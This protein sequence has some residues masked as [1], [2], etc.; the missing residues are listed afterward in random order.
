MLSISK[1][2]LQ[3]PI[4]LLI[5]PHD[6]L[7]FR[8]GRPYGPT[9][10]AHSQFPLPQTLAGM[11][12][13][14]LM[15]SLELSSR[16]IHG[17]REN[18]NQ[19]S[20][21]QRALAFIACRGPWLVKVKGDN[22]IEDLFVPAPAHLCRLDKDKEEKERSALLQPLENGANLPGWQSP[23][24]ERQKHLRPV[25]Y[26]KGPERVEPETRWLGKEAITSVLQA[27]VP[28]PDSLV[29]PEQLFAWENRTGVTI[30]PD[31]S[32]G[33]DSLLYSSSQLRFAKNVALYAEIGWETV[34]E[35]HSDTSEEIRAAFERE[36]GWN[37][38]FPETGVLL[39][40]GGEARRTSVRKIGTF[41]WPVV[42]QAPKT[43]ATERAF[44]WLISP[45]V[46]H[47]HTRTGGQR[48]PWEP[49]SLGKLVGAVCPRYLPV[50]GWDLAG[51]E[52]NN[53]RSRPRSTRYAVP[54]GAVYFWERRGN[55]EQNTDWLAGSLVQLAERPKDRANGWGMALKGVW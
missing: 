55:A 31:T 19:M 16:Q 5:E 47:Q 3:E 13:T 8:D 14:H 43:D 11:M 41:A 54:T 34:D 44:T 51:D 36:I 18:A 38:L 37:R 52:R 1:P 2:V 33:E 30:S 32:A 7:L 22:E 50:S 29:E 10:T 53:R 39:P 4:G 28:N 12:R 15:H 23:I 46:N 48:E 42:A 20:L 35:A 26:T 9:D 45:L 6:T 49:M 27:K 17:L 24:P 25:I 40:F 21:H